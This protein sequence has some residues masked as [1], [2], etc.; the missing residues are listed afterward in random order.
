MYNLA[1]SSPMPASSTCCF[2]SSTP[3][4]SALVVSIAHLYVGPVTLK[5]SHAGDVPQSL[6]FLKETRN[7]GTERGVLWSKGDVLL[8]CCVMVGY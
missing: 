6:Q 3:C 2:V 5:R 4:G 1:I 7:L 8:P